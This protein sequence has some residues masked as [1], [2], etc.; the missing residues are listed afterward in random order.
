MHKHVPFILAAL[1]LLQAAPARADEYQFP[2]IPASA[3]LPAGVYETVLTPDN[4]SGMESFIKAEGRTA[5]EY[6][7]E[8]NA[9]GILLKAYDR[10]EDRILVISALAD[11]DAGLYFDING[12]TPA[13]R[14]KYRAS[15]GD[16]GAYAVL[17]YDYDSIAWK[18]FANAGR[19]LMLR[20]SLRQSGNLVCRGFQ[21]RT[22]RN[23]LTITLD[24]QVYGRRLTAGDNTAL[25]RVFDTFRFSSILPMPPLPVTFTET[26]TAPRETDKPSFTLK[27]K[28]AP[29]ARL[30]AVL[31]PLSTNKAQVFAATAAKNGNYVLEVELPAEGF[32]VMTLSVEAEGA[33][34]VEKQYSINYEEGLLP[35][36]ILGEPPER[37]GGDVLTLAGTTLSG[38]EA[39]LTV[40]GKTL[41]KTTG[42]SG[43]FSFDV[44]TS[45]QGS[46]SIRLT[47][48][49]KGHDARAFEYFCERTDADSQRLQYVREN[50][51]AALCGELAADPEA[52]EG[53]LVAIDGIIVSKE[54]KEEEWEIVIGSEKAGSG[55]EEYAVLSAAFDPGFV[56]GEA[57]RAFGELIGAN[58]AA[59]DGGTEAVY[60]KLRLELMEP[61]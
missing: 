22:I 5:A 7:A 57:V 26:A 59:A 3:A 17:G 24:L 58:S 29:G 44:D 27:G 20:Y 32:Y 10:E 8:F 42:R 15:H 53:K 2:S 54:P 14:A 49:K 47:L 12:H 34:P 40:N 60:P 61:L 28:T 19:F 50:A 43:A 48:R 41:K 13:T 16:D 39:E 56:T 46:Y 37:I 52:F 30:S 1:L 23:G 21:R 11:V 36:S 31:I 6:L 38:V 35:V 18:N 4:L 33:L 45:A 25:N 51:V 9:K 55:V